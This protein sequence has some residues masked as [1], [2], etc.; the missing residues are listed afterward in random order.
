ML[1][2][3][4]LCKLIQ[5][6]YLTIELI[7]RVVFRTMGSCEADSRCVIGC[8]AGDPGAEG[9]WNHPVNIASLIEREA[10]LLNGALSPRLN[11]RDLPVSEL[12]TH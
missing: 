2:E 5:N 6:E 7:L 8:S 3:I 1:T 10:Y 11:K 4:L 12:H 9:T